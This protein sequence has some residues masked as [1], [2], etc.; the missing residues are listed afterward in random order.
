M[1]LTIYTACTEKT[2]LFNNKLTY[3]QSGSS[4]LH[5]LQETIDC[6]QLE[7]RRNSKTCPQVLCTCKDEGCPLLSSASSRG[8]VTVTNMVIFLPI[9]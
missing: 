2:S 1:T 7:E 3:I 4:N 5:H 9:V 6:I 8:Q